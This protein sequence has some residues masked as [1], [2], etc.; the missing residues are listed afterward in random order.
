MISDSKSNI[1][2]GVS[3]E[4]CPSET[5]LVGDVL[6]VV[7]FGLVGWG[8]LTFGG[9]E[10]GEFCNCGGDDGGGIYCYSKTGA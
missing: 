10:M 3:S 8:A 1:P 5:L 7:K 2:I 6:G 4:T 9:G